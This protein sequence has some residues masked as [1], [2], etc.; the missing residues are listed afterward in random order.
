MLNSTT[1][2]AVIEHALFLGADFAELF[3][4]HHQS[5]SVQLISGDIDR[6][7]SGIDFGIGIRLFL[8]LKSFTVIP[9]VLTKEN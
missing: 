7:N 8:G 6:V 3:V 1:A 2:K 5:S 9:I 4:E